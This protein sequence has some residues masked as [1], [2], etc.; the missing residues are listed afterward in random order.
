MWEC[1]NPNVDF[2]NKSED[3]L[4]E[5]KKEATLEI[6]PF[7]ANLEKLGQS[8]KYAL[9]KWKTSLRTT[10]VFFLCSNHRM[11]NIQNLGSKESFRG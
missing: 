9:Q 11:M 3:V 6:I 2:F 8:K 1:E 7:I 4:N 5:G 10:S